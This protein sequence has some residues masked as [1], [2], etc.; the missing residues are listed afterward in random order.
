MNIIARRKAAG[1]MDGASDEQDTRPLYLR[2]FPSTSSI[3][4]DFEL[5]VLMGRRGF[6]FYVLVLI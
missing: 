6:N 1:A 4:Q 3:L 2:V 5:G